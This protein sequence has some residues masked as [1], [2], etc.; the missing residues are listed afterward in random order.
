MQSSSSQPAEAGR[1]AVYAKLVFA[2]V[3]LTFLLVIVG[4]IVRTTGSGLGCGTA[5]GWRDW[6]LCDGGVL[7]PLVVHSVIEFTHRFLAFA[8]TAGVVT[9]AA[10]VARSQPLRVRLGAPVMLACGL[11]VG[12]IVLG[13]L[14]VR[15]LLPDKT[16]RPTFIVLHLATA[17]AFFGTL[18]FV[19]M[20]ARFCARPAA[21]G[22]YPAYLGPL[23]GVATLGVYLQTLLGGLVASHNAGLAC[24][25]FPLCNGSWIPTLAGP[26]GLQVMHR[27]GAYSV[28]ILVVTFAI[29]AWRH[30]GAARRGAAAALCL[31]ACQFALGVM[32]VLLLLPLAVR[33]AHNGTAFLLF[34][35]LLAT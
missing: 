8:V 19:A 35:T 15:L 31:V 16:I 7:P 10:A 22:A 6:P 23:A 13:A 9:M 4:V 33:A 1:F 2:L 24:A 32:N 26:V 25:G 18:L 27:L 5:G 28:V 34:G 20:R 14:T 3:A 30:G 11:L 12:Q 29:V 17:M 21:T